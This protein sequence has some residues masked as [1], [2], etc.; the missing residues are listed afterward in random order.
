MAY[1]GTLKYKLYLFNKKW[2]IKMSNVK[3]GM[4]KILKLL[5][6]GEIK[7]ETSSELVFRNYIKECEKKI[8]G[9]IPK[10]RRV[11]MRARLMGLNGEDKNNTIIFSGFIESLKE[12]VTIGIKNN[13]FHLIFIKGD[14]TLDNKSLPLHYLIKRSYIFKFDDDINVTFNHFRNET[15]HYNYFLNTEY[16]EEDENIKKP[17]QYSSVG[18]IGNRLLSLDEMI[19]RIYKKSNSEETFK[20]E[21]T[22]LKE[23]MIL[24]EKTVK[25]TRPPEILKN[26]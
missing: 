6:K 18:R 1:T 2:K 4:N 7:Q 24:L 22:R 26:D 10:L 9:Y 5:T 16:L 19:S 12:T 20:E 11:Q 21:V 23:S 17:E 25:N 13:L 8:K 14:L 3:D 15:I